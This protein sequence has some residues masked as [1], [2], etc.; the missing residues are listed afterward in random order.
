MKIHTDFHVERPF[1]HLKF[2]RFCNF[3]QSGFIDQMF[4]EE[5]LTFHVYLQTCNAKIDSRTTAW[6]IY[7]SLPPIIPPLTCHFAILHPFISLLAILTPMEYI[8]YFLSL[9]FKCHY[10]KTCLNIVNAF[11]LLS[12]KPCTYCSVHIIETFRAPN[13]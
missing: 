5:D 3:T 1:V 10:R 11:K 4:R 8:K 2:L 9:R 7:Y 13:Y 12:S 6:V